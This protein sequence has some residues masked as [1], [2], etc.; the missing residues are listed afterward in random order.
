MERM[1]TALRDRVLTVKNAKA[2]KFTNANKQMVEDDITFPIQMKETNGNVVKSSY[3]AHIID[4]DCPALWCL[5][6][7]RA[8][9]GV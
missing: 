7:I 5:P 1:S 4:T 2:F 9:G 6:S 3:R 8:L